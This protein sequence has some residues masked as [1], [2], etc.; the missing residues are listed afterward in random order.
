MRWRENWAVEMP[1]LWKSQN[2]FHKGL[3]KFAQN[4]SF[5]HFHKP[6]FFH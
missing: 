2:D 6:Y 3:G 1:T 5:P 4:A